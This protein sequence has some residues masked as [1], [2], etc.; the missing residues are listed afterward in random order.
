MMNHRDKKL[1]AALARAVERRLSEFNAQ[2]IA[3]LAWAFCTVNRQEEKLCTDLARAAERL[4]EF[5]QQA[6]HGQLTM[7]V[8]NGE[9]SG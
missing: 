2:D 1:F 3:N 6:E 4:G 8:C 7:G 5:E 9:P